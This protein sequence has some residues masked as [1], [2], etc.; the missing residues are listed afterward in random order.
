MNKK[1]T[2]LFLLIIQSIFTQNAVIDSLVNEDY[3]NLKVGL[4]KIE[5]DSITE[6]NHTQAYLRKAKKENN[7]VR[8]ADGYYFLSRIYNDELSLQ[9]LDSVISLS[10]KLKKHSK[11]PAIAYESKG[12]IFHQKGDFDNALKFYVLALKHTKND[13]FQHASVKFDIA[14]LKYRLGFREEAKQLFKSYLNELDK[15]DFPN[16][17]YYYNIGIYA[18]CDALIYT[19][20]LDSAQIMIDE[21]IKRTLYST[22][23]IL[24][25][26]FILNNGINSYYKKEYNKALKALLESIQSIKKQNDELTTAINQSYIGKTYYELGK[27]DSAITYLNKAHLFLQET[28]DVALEILDGYQ[29]LINHY[30]TEKEYDKQLL[31]INALMKF[32]SVYNSKSRRVSQQI[33]KN[34]EIPYLLSEKEKLISTLQQ[35]EDNNNNLKLVFL[36]LSFVA[37]IGITLLFRRNY[38][39][40]KRFALILN[41]NTTKKAIKNQENKVDD[42]IDEQIENDENDELEKVGV[43]EE[44]TQKILI[45]LK[46]FEDTQQFLKKKYTLSSLAKEIKTNSSYLS[47]VIN[48]KK[49]T[50]F[51]NYLNNLKIDYAINRLTNDKKFRSYTVKAISEESGFNSQQTFS[52]AF[53]KKTKLQPSY[54]IKQLEKK[55]NSE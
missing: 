27:K 54:F 10:K 24:K 11:Y 6:F 30:K 4:Q 14:S 28:N 53:V 43:S 17:G 12:L 42:N 29:Y 35:N 19:K 40:K 18:Y 7:L 9:Y 44:I 20:K 33:T 13:S 16:K 34:Y 49:G 41:E 32:D 2:F 51:A 5:V 45:D 46:K 23:E 22:D 3:E 1:L 31:Y 37:V 21:G 38:I 36:I 15:L 52:I 47:K 25:T 39:L 55:Q 26:R 50:N 48:Y 8:I